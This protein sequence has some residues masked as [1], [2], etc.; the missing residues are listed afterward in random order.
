MVIPVGLE[1]TAAIP[2]VSIHAAP[3]PVQIA[4]SAAIDPIHLNV[5]AINGTLTTFATVLGIDIDIGGVKV[6]LNPFSATVTPGKIAL[7]GNGTL[8]PITA[9]THLAGPVTGAVQGA[10]EAFTARA[11]ILGPI[12][13]NVDGCIKGVARLNPEN[14]QLPGCCEGYKEPVCCPCHVHKDHRYCDKHCACGLTEP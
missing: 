10:I 1:A 3:I 12:E 6:N 2:D 9:T 7:S 13:M 11:Q 14:L 5:G 8:G 4:G